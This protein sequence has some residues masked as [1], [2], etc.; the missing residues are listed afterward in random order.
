[1]D[2]MNT[3]I[4]VNDFFCHNHVGHKLKMALET[5]FFGKHGTDNQQI[6]SKRHKLLPTLSGI[7]NVEHGNYVK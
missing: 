7:N 2:P 1:M 3:T 6:L 5:P 4:H